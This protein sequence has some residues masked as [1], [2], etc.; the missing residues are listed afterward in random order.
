[1][2]GKNEKHRAAAICKNCGTAHAVRI[3]S[4]GEIYPIGTGQRPA[5]TCGNGDFHLMSDDTDIQDNVDSKKPE[6]D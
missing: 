3:G 5:C 4:D 2:A 1:M 6:R